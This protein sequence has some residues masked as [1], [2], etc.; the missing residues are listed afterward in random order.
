MTEGTAV[1]REQ[2]RNILISLKEV[3]DRSGYIS[4]TAIEEI[5]R[6]FDTSVADV[7]GIATFYSFLRISP[8]GRHIIRICQS[9]PCHLKEGEVVRKR[10]SDLLGI[11]PGETTPDGRFS[12]EV[13]N[14]IGACDAAPAML[15]D[16]QV[17]G[18]LTTDNIAAILESYR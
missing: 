4:G 13:T 17:R 2:E 11:N 15:V 14:C 3:Q 8:P 6:S 1:S 5:A 18:N 7:Y 9:L 10:L 12:L 16:D